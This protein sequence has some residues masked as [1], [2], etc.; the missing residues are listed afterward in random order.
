LGGAV[1]HGLAWWILAGGEQGHG[2]A[3]LVG[4][5]L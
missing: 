1:R 4:P 3:G 2:Q 5:E